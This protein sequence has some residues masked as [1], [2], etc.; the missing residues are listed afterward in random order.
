M[1]RNLN[2][3]ENERG[4]TALFLVLTVVSLVLIIGLVVDGGGKVQ[5]ATNAQQ[6]AASAARAAAN[7]ISGTTMVGQ[8]LSVDSYKAQ[9]AAS[10]Y[11]AASGMEGTVAVDG[12]TVTVTT[13]TTYA[14]RFLSLIGITHL[15]VDGQATAQL[16]D[17]PTG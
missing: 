1:F 10:G 16:I 14:T 12:F 15:P 9:E 6:T 17:G 5:A 11:I 4:S 2:Q 7:S 13:S 3:A 8:T